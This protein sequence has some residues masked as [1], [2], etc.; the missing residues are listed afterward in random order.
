MKMTEKAWELKVRE[1]RGLY[2]KLDQNRFKIAKLA[3]EA[4]DMRHGGDR[5]RRF[6][7]KK[8]AMALG[9]Y[10]K[11]L[12]EW[13][14]IKRQVVDK[15]RVKEDLNKVPYNIFCSVRKRVDDKT[16]PKQV[17][18]ILN[19]ELNRDPTIFKWRKYEEVMGTIL[20]NCQTPVKLMEI[21]EE[22]IVNT[23]SKARLIAKLLTME[24]EYRKSNKSGAEARVISET[25]KF[26]SGISAAEEEL[27]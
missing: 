2:L 9:L 21:P 4:C 19:E 10:H 23:V 16:S 12:Y 24:L 5:D 8:F 20:N 1:A 27:K 11:T 17:R 15:L 25:K 18:I 3:L 22:I 14:A 26:N 6:T 13:I 7:V